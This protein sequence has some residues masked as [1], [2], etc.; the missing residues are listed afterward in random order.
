[1]PVG[2]R[3][4]RRVRVL[5][6]V[7]ADGEVADGHALPLLAIVKPERSEGLLNRA[8]RD[9]NSSVSCTH[10][11]LYGM[12]DP[13]T[14]G[15]EPQAR[16]TRAERL[17]GRLTALEDRVKKAGAQLRQAEAIEKERERKRATR[18]KIILGGALM[19][20]AG[21]GDLAAHRIIERALERLPER[22]TELFADWRLPGPGRGDDGRAEGTDGD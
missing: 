18:R 9:K 19:R 11:I 20:Q 12:A 7:R 1:M 13:T 6:A 4:R 16:P 22:E 10:D 21:E 17:R 14:T 8:L 15:P 5:A 2:E 3:G